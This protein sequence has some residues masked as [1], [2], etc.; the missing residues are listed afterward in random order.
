MRLIFYDKSDIK[1]SNFLNHYFLYFHQYDALLK[2]LYLRPI[3]NLRIYVH[4]PKM[5]V[6]YSEF[7]FHFHSEKAKELEDYFQY[8]TLRLYILDNKT[9]NHFC[10]FAF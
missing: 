8:A 3:H 5:R 2:C 9:I 10:Y 7:V 6:F 1:S 4:I